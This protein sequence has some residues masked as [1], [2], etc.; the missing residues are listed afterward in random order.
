MCERERERERERGERERERER[1]RETERDRETD[2]TGLRVQT[3]VDTDRS[4][5]KYMA[6]NRQRVHD[7]GRH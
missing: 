2:N 4:I 1:E 6:I 7:G 5:D 3:V